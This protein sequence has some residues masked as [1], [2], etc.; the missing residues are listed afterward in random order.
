MKLSERI[1]ANRNR[2]R[3]KI[4]VEKWSD[5]TE[6]VVIYSTPLTAGDLHKL[7]RKHKDFLNNQTIEGMIDLIL[8]KAEDEDGKKV[9]TLEDKPVLMREDVG[10]IAEIAAQM[11]GDASDIEE[12]E[13]N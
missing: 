8:M 4:P 3:R 5:E 2:D 12:L 11:F 10:T 7:Q 1:S 6:K 13:K 9:F